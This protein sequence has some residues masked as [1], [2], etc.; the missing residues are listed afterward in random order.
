MAGTVPLKPGT[1]TKPLGGERAGREPL[2]MEENPVFKGKKGSY[3]VLGDQCIGSGGESQVFLARNI[4]NGEIVV[5]K[6]YDQFQNTRTNRENRN[7]VIDFVQKHSDYRN[8]HIMP[9]IDYG[10][11]SVNLIGEEIPFQYPIDILPFCKDGEIKK[12]SFDELRQSIIPQIVSAIHLMHSENLAHRDIKPGNIYRYNNTIVIADFGTSCA[13]GQ[14]EMFGTQT[15][16]GTLGYTA[17]EVWQGYVV[18]ASDYYSLG[19]TIATLYK[20]EHVYQHLIDLND[21]GAINRSINAGGLPLNCPAGEESL[22]TLVD[23]L[24]VMRETDRVGYDGVQLWL[25]DPRTFDQKFKRK[26]LNEEE[27]PFEIKFN[28]VMCYSERDLASLMSKHWEYS[29]RNLY[30]NNPLLPHFYSSYDYTKATKIGEILEAKE[31]AR[32][33]DY[34]LAKILHLIY[35]EGPIYWKGRSF[36]KL[37]DIS[38][39]ISQKTVPEDDIAAMLSCGYISWKLSNIS[40]ASPAV[41]QGVKNVEEIAKNYKRLACFYAK[42]QFSKDGKQQSFHGLT[43]ADDIFAQITKNPTVFNQEGVLYSDD[44]MLAYLAFLGFKENVLYFKSHLGSDIPKNTELAYRFFEAVCT[45]KAAVRACYIRYSPRSYLYWVKQNLDLYSF[46]S[47]EAKQI[48]NNIVNENLDQSKTIDEISRHFIRLSEY[49]NDF[50]RLFHNN[51]LLAFMGIGSGKDTNGIT[52][53]NSDA[54]F[55]ESYCGYTVPVGFLR[56]INSKR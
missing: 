23:A 11:V 10:W 53:T 35:P 50:M 55:L 44:E 15:R 21:E 43:A 17:P 56:Y 6:I 48:R 30:S 24:T 9:I 42:Y 51:V 38:D 41:I 12:A 29:K 33:Q 7:Q 36:T 20:G 47:A 5:A 28:D 3:E 25:S 34:G 1:G 39:A 13:I 37:S 54:Y 19:C 26:K 32:N 52:S 16:R 31:T 2:L 18:M 46:N 40:D 45:N 22:Q 27:K 4:D 8:T 49:I 14:Y